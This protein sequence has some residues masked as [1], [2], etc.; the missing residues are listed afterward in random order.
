MADGKLRFQADLQ[1]PEQD[2]VYNAGS[3]DRPWDHFLGRWQAMRPYVAQTLRSLGT[4]R[5]LRVVDVG[6][7]TGF[8]ALQVAHLHPEADVVGVEGSVGVGN[9][10]AGMQGQA[11]QILHT[12]AVQTH[13]RYIQKE[14]LP[15]CFVAPEVWDYERVREL[16]STGRPI[17]DIQILLSVVHHIDGVSH[18]QYEEA[19]LSL[20]DGFTQLMAQILRLSPFHFIELPNRPWIAPSYDKYGSARNILEAAAKASGKTWSF[21]GPIYSAEWFGQRELWI[22]ESVVPMPAVDVQHCPFPL[23]YRGDEVDLEEPLVQGGDDVEFGDDDAMYNDLLFGSHLGADPS[24]DA[25]NAS[26]D[27]L[28]QDLSMPALPSGLVVDPGLMIL[29][30]GG[31]REPVE[32]I[33]GKA[34]STA[35]TELLVAHLALRDAVAEAKLILQQANESR[36]MDVMADDRDMGARHM[37][38]AA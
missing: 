14:Q 19:G 31:L 7:C 24:P 12:S 18:H 37:V 5:P 17:C 1:L 27:Y 22:M 13:L 38:Q 33:I 32:P 25:R 34:L 23:L 36:S 35:S 10:R 6:S 29:A 16:A 4:S 28:L 3:T 15:N 21:K 2:F 9:G 8:F 26:G 30:D 20:A 11:R